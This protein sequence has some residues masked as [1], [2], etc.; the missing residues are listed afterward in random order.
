[1]RGILVGLLLPAIQAAREA[2]RKVRCQNNLKQQGLALLSFHDRSN[3]FP[4]GLYYYSARLTLC[5]SDKL[6][7]L[8]GP[9]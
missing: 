3:K 9:C 5:K 6:A 8:P 1:M 7:N 4:F 2:A